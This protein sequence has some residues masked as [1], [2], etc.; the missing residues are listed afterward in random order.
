MEMTNVPVAVVWNEDGHLFARCNPTVNGAKIKTTGGFHRPPY[1]QGKPGLHEMQARGEKIM[2]SRARDVARFC[3]KLYHRG[4][5]DAGM[6]LRTRQLVSVPLYVP[7]NERVDPAGTRQ[8]N[9]KAPNQ[10]YR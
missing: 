1:R 9:G 4:C 3:R 8:L 6:A 2:T 7:E 5:T 10:K